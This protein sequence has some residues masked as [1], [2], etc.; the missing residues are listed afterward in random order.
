MFARPQK[1]IPNYKV[2]EVD[3]TLTT[4]GKNLRDTPESF[5]EPIS[6]PKSA[7]PRTG[8]SLSFSYNG[9][10]AMN[11]P[12]H[13]AQRMYRIV[14]YTEDSNG[15]KVYFDLLD[16]NIYGKGPA[17]TSRISNNVVLYENRDTALG[18]RFPSN[19]VL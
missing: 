19:Q 15:D 6:R 18:E 14:A 13:A 8:D 2:S 16:G 9:N 11:I 10:V 1:I 12:E 5:I 7:P 4:V 17:F 3:R